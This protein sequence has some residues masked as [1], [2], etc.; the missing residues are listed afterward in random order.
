MKYFDDFLYA[1]TKTNYKGNQ[2]IVQKDTPKYGFIV[3]DNIP[4]ALATYN[5]DKGWKKTPFGTFY[6]IMDAINLHIEVLT[7]R[8][9]INFSRERHSPF[10]NKLFN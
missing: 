6:K 9:L 3:M 4:K 10:F 5:L 7:F 2:I 8:Q 1:E